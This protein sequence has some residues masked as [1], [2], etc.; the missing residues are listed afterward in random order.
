MVVDK[1]WWWT[2]LVG[3][4]MG[5]RLGMDDG[6]GQEGCASSYGAQLKPAE[7]KSVPGQTNGWNC[8]FAGSL[9]ETNDL[10]SCCQT[11]LSSCLWKRKSV[12]F[13]L[14]NT[15]QLGPNLLFGYCK[16]RDRPE[17]WHVLKKLWLPHAAKLVID[18]TRLRLKPKK[19][20]GNHSCLPPTL[21]FAHILLRID[22]RYFLSVSTVFSLLNNLPLLPTTPAT[23]FYSKCTC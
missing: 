13:K 18:S 20:N 15:A 10:C 17:S 7:P 21:F 11:T 9:R 6:D 22:L 19:A 14:I 4:M 8:P 2:L 3:W 23:W 1:R 5:M 16:L 12:L